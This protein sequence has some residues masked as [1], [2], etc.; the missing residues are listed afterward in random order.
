[1]KHCHR[2]WCIVFSSGWFLGLQ[3]W[4]CDEKVPS[5][6]FGV[7]FIGTVV[8][9]HQLAFPVQLVEKG[10]LSYKILAYS[11]LKMEC[12]YSLWGK[13][14]FSCTKSKQELS[15]YP[16]N[17]NEFLENICWQLVCP[18][19]LLMETLSCREQIEV[20]NHQLC[21]CFYFLSVDC[22]E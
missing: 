10:M 17:A 16:V 3:T 19:L 11:T 2:S 20:V 22:K 15:M 6:E 8:E 18:F 1:M 7:E 12:M 9:L 14:C 5:P 21:A 4:R 13:G